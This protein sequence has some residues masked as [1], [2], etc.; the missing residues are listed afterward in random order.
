MVLDAKHGEKGIKVRLYFYTSD[1]KTKKRAWSGGT[2]IV[3]ANKAHG[4]RSE[5]IGKVIHFEDLDGI[6]PAVKN[7]LKQADITLVTQDSKT[8][9][10]TLVDLD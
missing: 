3:M 9:N 2:V 10:F 6:L 7:A 8:K 1:L 4:L 5:N